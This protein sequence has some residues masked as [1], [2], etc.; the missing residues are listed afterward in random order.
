MGELHVVFGA[1]G[2]LGS[3]I[4]RRLARDGVTV[5]AVVRDVAGLECAPPPGVEVFH[6]D[7]VY[8]HSAIQAAKGA[9][10]IYRCIPARYS[11]WADVWLLATENTIAAAQAA[12]ARLVSPGNVYVYGPLGTAPATEEHPLGATGVKGRLRIATQE[13]LFRAHRSGA[14]PVVIPRF[15]DV[16][17]PCVTNRVYG[18][19]FRHVVQG[20]SVRWFG[21]L[22]APRSLLDVEDAAAAA[23]LLGRDPEAYGRVWHVAGPPPMTP[24][25]FIDLVSRVADTQVRLRRVRPL[26]VHLRSL[27]DAETRA[28]LEFRY[29]FEQPQVLDGTRF[30]NAYPDFSYTPPED[31]VR[32]TLEWFSTAR[33]ERRV[34]PSCV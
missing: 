24:R 21:D 1:N 2:S 8:R 4:V 28:F 17:G 20:K 30:A 26:D 33:V 18:S 12:G 34:E 29:L 25:E 11:L 6:G 31:S 19:L 32:R 13:A 22:D 3:A 23:V 5:R 16:Y 27:V 14:V 7:A 10:V 15:P 9:A